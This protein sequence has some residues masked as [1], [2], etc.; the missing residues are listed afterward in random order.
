MYVEVV[1]PSKEEFVKRWNMFRGE[2]SNLLVDQHMIVGIISPLLEDTNEGFFHDF[3]DYFIS[4]Y[5][6]IRDYLCS[7]ERMMNIHEDN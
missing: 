4:H 6:N 7:I 5:Y 2:I 3:D 1:N